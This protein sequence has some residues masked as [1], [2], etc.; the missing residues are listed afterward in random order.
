MLQGRPIFVRRE[1]VRRYLW[2]K[3]EESHWSRENGA[4]QRALS[5]YGL[6]DDDVPG[7]TSAAGDATPGMDDSKDG[8][9]RTTSGTVVE[10]VEQRPERLPRMPEAAA[11]LALDRMTQ[12][13]TESIVLHELGEGLAGEAL[14]TDWE[15]LLSGLARSQAQNPARA[16]RGNLP[17]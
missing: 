13:E 3:V 1:S 8:G 6:A 5:C 12:N 14:G 15:R 10:E 9:G 17:A 7:C 2:E 16:G 4:M 11:E